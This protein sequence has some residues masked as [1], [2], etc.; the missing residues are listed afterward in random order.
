MVS[1]GDIDLI[2]LIIYR[3]EERREFHASYK[4]V[5]ISQAISKRTIA[6]DVL[7]DFGFVAD[8]SFIGFHLRQL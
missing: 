1:D 8:S 3:K 5:N 6:C 4:Q 7:I 2:V